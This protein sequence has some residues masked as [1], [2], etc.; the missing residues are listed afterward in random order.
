MTENTRLATALE[1]L[2]SAVR[3]IAHGGVD[4]PAGLEALGMDLVGSGR[5]GHDSL[6]SAIRDAGESV[7]A[8]LRAVAEAIAEESG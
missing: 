7:E 5:P 1:S 4:G 8:G 3:A 2:A 6:A